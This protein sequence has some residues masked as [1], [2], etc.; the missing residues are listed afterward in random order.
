MKD[1]LV[2]LS[3]SPKM[4]F[5]L[6]YSIKNTPTVT[7]KWNFIQK[8]KYLSF[9]LSLLQPVTHRFF[10]E[11]GGMTSIFYWYPIQDGSVGNPHGKEESTAGR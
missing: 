8:V 2:L 6:A 11:R 5:E 9:S 1:N 10:V 7:L 4:V 3:F